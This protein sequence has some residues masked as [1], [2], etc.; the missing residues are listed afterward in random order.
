MLPPCLCV[1]LNSGKLDL[2]MT[3]NKAITINSALPILVDCER[4][5]KEDGFATWAGGEPHPTAV[6]LFRKED[7]EKL[8]KTKH[9]DRFERLGRLIGAMAR[10]DKVEIEKWQKELNSTIDTESAT[11]GKYDPDK[12]HKHYVGWKNLMANLGVKPDEERWYGRR[13]RRRKLY[14]FFGP[15]IFRVL[16]L[17]EPVYSPPP[18]GRRGSKEREQKKLYD[19]EFK[20]KLRAVERKLDEILVGDRLVPTLENEI[21]LSHWQL[22]SLL[23]EARFVLWH[24]KQRFQ[25]ALYCGGNLNV[26]YWAY[27]FTKSF[28]LVSSNQALCRFCGKPFVTRRGSLYCT[29]KHQVADGMRRMRARNKR[30]RASSED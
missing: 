18:V 21:N 17:E 24:Y 5:E 11:I 12:D 19:K 28:F 22:S 15:S 20:R 3:H 29:P 30:E 16:G 25:P 10:K 14:S 23:S 4:G 13:D 26:A 8:R 2:K 1:H 7:A 9:K 6:R 27:L